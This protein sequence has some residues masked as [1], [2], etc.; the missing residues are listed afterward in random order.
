MNDPIADLTIR[1]R[2]ALASGKKEVVLPFSR[3]KERMA[4]IL[5]KEGYLDDVAIEDGEVGKILK[6]RLGYT[7]DNKPKARELKRV[8]KPGRR[9]YEGYRGLKPIKQGLGMA[10]LSTPQGLMTDRQAR[11]QKLGGEILIEIF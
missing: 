8:S 9:V 10:I 2:N 1:L 3:M 5:K 11:K 4:Q 6:I 7:D